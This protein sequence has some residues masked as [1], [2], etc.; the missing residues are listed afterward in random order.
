MVKPALVPYRVEGAISKNKINE[1]EAEAIVSLILACCEME[2]YK[3]KTFGVITLRGEKQAAVIDRMLQKRMS[4]S[5][6]SKR[7]I[8][9]G[10]SANFQGDERDI[11]FLSMVDTN[12]GEGPLRFNGYGPDDLY[13]K[14]YNVAVSRAKDQIWLV[15]SL[16]TEEDLKPGDIRKELINYFKNPHGKDIE[17]QRRSLEAESEFEKEV[18]KYLIFKGYKIV[19]QWQV[20]AYRIDMVAIYG[21]KKVAIECDGERWHGEDKIEEDMIRQSILER[22][23]WTFIRIRGSEFYSNK[24]ET[25]ELVIKKLEALKVYPYTNSNESLQESKYT[26]VDK[27]KQVAAKIKKSWN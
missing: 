24:E 5:E 12:E 26:L 16:D 25:I 18:M 27:V 2:E 9:C 8:L 4:P 13:K 23:G 22:L 1:K 14:R 11:I 21:D 19:P 6:Y 20:G 15:Y 10:N 3:D 17:Y 7:E